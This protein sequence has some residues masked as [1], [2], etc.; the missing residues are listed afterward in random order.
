MFTRWS[1]LYAW[2]QLAKV[3]LTSSEPPDHKHRV[4]T[5]TQPIEPLTAS[6]AL[7]TRGLDP[8]TLHR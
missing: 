1:H 3:R 5:P 2:F 7:P 4:L 6:D 8:R